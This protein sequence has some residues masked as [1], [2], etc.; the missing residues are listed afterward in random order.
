LVGAAP[1][2]SETRLFDWDISKY[3][4]TYSVVDQSEFK[5]KPLLSNHFFIKSYCSI[6][7]TNFDRLASFMIKLESSA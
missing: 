4:W 2:R 7:N 1:F 6:R 3:Y 5:I